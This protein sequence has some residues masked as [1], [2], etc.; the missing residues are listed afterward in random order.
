ME[1]REVTADKKR[2]LPLLLLADPC[3]AM[4]DGYLASGRL[5][6][7]EQ[8]GAPVCTAVVSE[9]ARCRL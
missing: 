9:R 2:L 4:I 8:D 1:I 7:A 5:F 6:V 3:E